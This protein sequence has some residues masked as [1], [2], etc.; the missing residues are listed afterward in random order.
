MKFVFRYILLLSLLPAAGFSQTTMITGTAPGAEGKTFRVIRYTDLLTFNEEKM[1][2]AEIDSSGNFSVSFDPGTTLLVV[3]SIGLHRAE[4]YV[5]PGQAYRISIGA[6][7]YNE[8]TEVNPFIQSQSLM[9]AIVDPVENTLNSWIQEYNGKY[10]RFLLDH[11]NELYLERRKNLIDTFRLTVNSAFSQVSIPYFRNF[12]TY[13]T[14]GLEQVAKALSQSQLVKQYFTG[15]PVLYDN[16]EYMQFFSNLFSKFLTATSPALR[17]VDMTPVIKGPQPFSNLM[18]VLATDTVLRDEQIR[19]LVLLKGMM[20]L[21][22]S[23]PAMQD[24]VLG[25]I[26]E[27]MTGCKYDGNRLVAKDMDSKMNRLRPGSKAPLFS[28]PDKDHKNI[29]LKDLRGKP[30]LLSFWTTYC[31]GCLTE[32][33]LMT[34]LYPKYKDKMEFVS[35]SADNDF[36]KMSY[37]IK[38]KPAYTWTF[39]YLDNQA[40]LLREYDV[41]AYPLFVLIDKDGNMIKYPAPAPSEGLGTLLDRVTGQ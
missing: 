24:P 4:M 13:K 5:E 16:L 30:V 28:L 11:F 20:E 6:L 37:F 36:I 17:K 32:M 8:K 29:A 9:V 40:E 1:G 25:V 26:H 22:Y 2:V 38:M 7:D 34:T 33:E 35:V 18:K 10:D 14:A 15:K 41:R 39:L 27:A 31:G 3:L 12:V 23:D 21:F 19:E